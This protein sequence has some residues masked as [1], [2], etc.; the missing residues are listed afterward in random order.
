MPKA[1][2]RLEGRQFFLDTSILK[3][4]GYHVERPEFLA[5]AD[6]V[7]KG[8]VRALTTSLTQF[9]VAYH[10]KADLNAAYEARKVL[11]H[12]GSVLS[13]L[14]AYTAVFARG[15]FN[16]DWA[17]LE[18]KVKG[19]WDTLKQRV[20]PVDHVDAGVLVEK[21]LSQRPPFGSGGKRYEF[22][23]AD[24]RVALE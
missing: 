15:Q 22:K 11:Q 5:L 17:A 3:G 12:D 9:E 19:F 8:T 1:T 7:K 20:V 2:D 10:L 6:L 23:D 18:Q 4:A 16:A 24:R 14:E 21:F 13:N